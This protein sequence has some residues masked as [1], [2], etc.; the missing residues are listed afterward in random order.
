M[1]KMYRQEKVLGQ[2]F[3]PYAKVNIWHTTKNTKKQKNA[4]RRNN[5]F[6]SNELGI[7]LLLTKYPNLL[8]RQ[9]TK[10][11]HFLEYKNIVNQNNASVNRDYPSELLTNGSIEGNITSSPKYGAASSAQALSSGAQ[12]QGKKANLTTAPFGWFLKNAALVPGAHRIRRT[13]SYYY[14][15]K[16]SW[17]TLRVWLGNPGKIPMIKFLQ[18]TILQSHSGLETGTF[19][20]RNSMLFLTAI[21]SLPVV[22]YI[23]SFQYKNS[24]ILYSI[25]RNNLLF[26][27]GFFMNRKCWSAGPGTRG[28]WSILKPGDIL[29]Y[30]K[31]TKIQK[32][33]CFALGSRAKREK[34]VSSEQHESQWVGDP[35][36]LLRLRRK[37]ARAAKLHEASQMLARRARR[38]PSGK[39]VTCSKAT[40]KA[41]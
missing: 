21:E 7:R 11:D 30:R 18:K 22:L 6:F 34:I 32:A 40:D 14:V 26:Q 19:G 16:N 8:Y 35:L 1:R 38:S 24:R 9:K 5:G 15:Q 13:K 23:K 3:L 12:H 29:G 2:N 25:L 33:K 27:S 31:I 41:K 37:R 20:Y 28:Q 36:G 10:N 17:K 39:N 4:F